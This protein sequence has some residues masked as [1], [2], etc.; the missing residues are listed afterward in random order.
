MTSYSIFALSGEPVD[1][2]QLVSKPTTLEGYGITDAVGLSGDQT[3]AGVKTFSSAPVL[4]ALA[5]DPASPVNGQV[6][7][8]A[9]TGQLK[10]RIGGVTKVFNLT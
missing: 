10:A 8:N 1:W 7:L 6:W 5:S 4:A 3:I 9:T 2:S